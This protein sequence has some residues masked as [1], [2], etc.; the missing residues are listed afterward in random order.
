VRFS[1]PHQR[2]FISSLPKT[3]KRR[4][5]PVI[6]RYS[7]SLELSLSNS[8]DN[9]DLFPLSRHNVGT[10]RFNSKDHGA[11]T[12]LASIRCTVFRDWD[13]FGRKSM[14]LLLPPQ[15]PYPVTKSLP[16]LL[17]C[18]LYRRFIR[19]EKESAGASEGRERAREQYGGEIP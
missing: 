17:I 14:P 15:L 2:L 3:S 11:S 9:S 19:G 6:S 7:R 5:A 13:S 4:I 8:L 1:S 18:H 10:Y 16:F 12:V